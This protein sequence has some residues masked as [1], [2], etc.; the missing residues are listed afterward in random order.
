MDSSIFFFAASACFF[1]SSSTRLKLFLLRSHKGKLF[2]KKAFVRCEPLQRFFLNKAT[3]SG[4][5]RE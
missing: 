5:R 2:A 4:E 3:V 1:F